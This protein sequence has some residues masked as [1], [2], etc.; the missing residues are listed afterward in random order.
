[1]IFLFIAVGIAHFFVV[2]DTVQR[3][4]REVDMAMLDELGHIAIEERE[5]QCPDV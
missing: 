1:M 5:K 3:R 4:H 2:C